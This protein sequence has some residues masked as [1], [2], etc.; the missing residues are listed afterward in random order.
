MGIHPNDVYLLG[1]DLLV[2]P[3]TTRGA[4][5]REVPFPPGRWFDFWTGEA[6]E[7]GTTASIPAPLGQIP[8]FL[9][10]GAILPLLRPTIDTLSPTTQPDRVDS[11]ATAPGVLYARI[12]AGPASETAVLGDTRLQAERAG[13]TLSLAVEQGSLFTGVQFEIIATGGPP[14]SVTIDNDPLPQAASLAELE[15]SE[16]AWYHD[17]S[18]AGTLHIRVGAGDHTIEATFSE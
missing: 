7:G 16:T 10:E 6:R 8:V 3:V 9:R 14:A 2:A 11:F 15:A 12:A 17:P 5:S 18:V 13:A 1:D 4:R